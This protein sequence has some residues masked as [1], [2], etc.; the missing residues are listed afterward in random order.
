MLSGA[1]T[2]EQRQAVAQHLLHA[3]HQ[4]Q[5]RVAQRGVLDDECLGVVVGVEDVG[6]LAQ[7][8]HQRVRRAVDGRLLQHLG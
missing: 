1:D 7:V 6:E 2:P 5:A 4:R 3:E 8:V